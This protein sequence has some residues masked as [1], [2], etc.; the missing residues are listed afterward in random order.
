RY[1]GG[2][3]AFRCRSDTRMLPPCFVKY[4]SSSRME[5]A[6]ALVAAYAFLSNCAGFSMGSFNAAT[7][8]RVVKPLGVARRAPASD[9][10]RIVH[11]QRARAATAM[12]PRAARRGRVR[13]IVPH[14]DRPFMPRLTFHA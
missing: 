10:A 12:R 11:P 14:G 5:I 8:H 7:G 13:R 4:S 9:V 2:E 3:P 1:T 6:L